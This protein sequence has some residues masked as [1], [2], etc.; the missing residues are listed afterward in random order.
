V[1]SLTAQDA[2]T[3]PDII[4]VPALFS[5]KHLLCFSFAQHDNGNIAPSRSNFLQWVTVLSSTA[6]VHVAPLEYELFNVTNS[7]SASSGLVSLPPLT[8]TVM[9]IPGLSGSTRTLR[10]IAM[11]GNAAKLWAEEH[12]KAPFSPLE[13]IGSEAGVQLT[14][15]TATVSAD[16]SYTLSAK[17]SAWA[18]PTFMLLVVCDG[19]IAVVDA[20]PPAYLKPGVLPPPPVFIMPQLVLPAVVLTVDP[21]AFPSSLLEGATFAMRVRVPAAGLPSSLT[22][23]GSTTSIFYFFARALK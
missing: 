10:V 21:V 22:L 18:Q 6:S 19:I 5:H 15:N 8:V 1:F 13:T 20:V 9:A 11:E 14:D 3:V 23:Q 2:W 12:G 7:F 17:V 4:E 16:A